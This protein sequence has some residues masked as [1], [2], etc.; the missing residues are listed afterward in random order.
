MTDDDLYVTERDALDG[1][2]HPRQVLRLIAEVR[3][4]RA[5]EAT[6]VQQVAMAAQAIERL[7]AAERLA[8]AYIRDDHVQHEEQEHLEM[9]CEHDCP[10]C[11]ELEAAEIAYRKVKS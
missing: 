3:R 8:E 11:R 9:V 2:L 1:G 10:A 5:I 6:A 7:D 4:L